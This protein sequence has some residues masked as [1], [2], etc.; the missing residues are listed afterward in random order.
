MRLTYIAVVALVAVAVALLA[1]TTM[2]QHESYT[3]KEITD[4]GNDLNSVDSMLGQF[5]ALDNM[6]LSEVNDSL[7]NP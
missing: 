2:L 5:D 1:Y 4:L 6:N 7:F 3:D